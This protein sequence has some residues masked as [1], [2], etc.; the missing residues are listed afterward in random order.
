MQAL[1]PLAPVICTTDASS[2]MP[3]PLLQYTSWSLTHSTVVLEL[4]L[5][6][7]EPRPDESRRLRLLLLTHYT[8]GRYMV[9]LNCC[10]IAGLGLLWEHEG[11]S[12]LHLG[13]PR[14]P[15]GIDLLQYGLVLYSA[16]AL[17]IPTT[18]G[19]ELVTS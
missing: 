3:L 13:R 1:D 2:S 15:A 11:L 19:W 17:I 10:L 16:T 5:S 7:A 14:Q 4:P 6:H 12:G 9:T 8:H 18:P